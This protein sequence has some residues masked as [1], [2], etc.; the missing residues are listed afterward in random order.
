MCKL[1]IPLLNGMG[2]QYILKTWPCFEKAF[3]KAS[4]LYKLEKW[5]DWSLG[6][7]ECRGVS[8]YNHEMKV[9]K[10]PE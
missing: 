9:I 5:W 3:K 8:K 4:S 1:V 7:A 2:T 6:N 10:V